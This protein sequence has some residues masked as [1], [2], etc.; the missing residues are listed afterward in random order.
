MSWPSSH[1]KTQLVSVVTWATGSRNRSSE[2]RW[3]CK[4]FVYQDF[5]QICLLVA[6]HLIL[7]SRALMPPYSWFVRPQDPRQSPGKLYALSHRVR[8]HLSLEVVGGTEPLVLWGCVQMQTRWFWE[9]WLKLGLGASVHVGW[10]AAN[11]ATVPN[12]APLLWVRAASLA[13]ASQVALMH[14]AQNLGGSYVG[15]RAIIFS[16]ILL[17]LCLLPW[18][19]LWL[20][21]PVVN[22][23]LVSTGLILIIA[24]SKT[25]LISAILV[26]FSLVFI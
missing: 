7:P 18:C 12:P 8:L 17:L 19:Y 3:R 23:K 10:W 9:Q 16:V 4:S 21:I 6:F 25:F 20:C 24:A 22:V 5:D 14:A 11:V 26:F 1:Q 13:E 15:S 2:R